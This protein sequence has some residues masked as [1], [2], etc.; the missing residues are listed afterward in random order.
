MINELLVVPYLISKRLLFG[1]IFLFEVTAEITFYLHRS[2]FYYPMIPDRHR[3]LFEECPC[4]CWWLK[5]NAISRAVLAHVWRAIYEVNCELFLLSLIF[6]ANV[7]CRA[8]RRFY[9]V[10]IL[11]LLLLWVWVADK[12]NLAS[13]CVAF[14]NF[15]AHFSMVIYSCCPVF[16]DDKLICFHLRCFL[17]K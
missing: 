14:Y 7:C 13:A 6:G 2:S 3:L 10:C 5:L 8:A 9:I 4:P 12:R 15:T 1:N 16:G 11:F 17:R